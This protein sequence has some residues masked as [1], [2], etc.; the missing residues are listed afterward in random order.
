MDIDSNNS[1]LECAAYCVS[2]NP[3]AEL[4]K[5]CYNNHHMHVECITELITKSTVRCPVC[6]DNRILIKLQKLSAMYDISSG[7]EPR[8]RE[9]VV[10]IMRDD[11]STITCE[12]GQMGEREACSFGI[13]AICVILCI[14]GLILV[15]FSPISL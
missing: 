15:V 7:P 5:I 1:D 13:Y 2:S 3:D 6:R 12:C 4:I 11:P 14:L 10:T 9:H 8:R